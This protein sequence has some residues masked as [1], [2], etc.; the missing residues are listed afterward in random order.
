MHGV[1][2]GVDHALADITR[3]AWQVPPTCS[4]AFRAQL[5]RAFTLP[6][7]LAAAVVAGSRGVAATIAVRAGSPVTPPSRA[8]SSVRGEHRQRQLVL[9]TQRR[10]CVLWLIVC[11]TLVTTAPDTPWQAPGQAGT[12]GL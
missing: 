10:W 6:P 1:D 9:M 8:S 3:C 11:S 12:S 7:A 4:E 5:E 2:R